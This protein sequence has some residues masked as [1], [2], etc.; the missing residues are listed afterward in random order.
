LAELSDEFVIKVPAG[1]EEMSGV[2][3]AI[4]RL[5]A[6]RALCQRMGHLARGYVEQEHDLSLA[7]DELLCFLDRPQDVA[8]RTAASEGARTAVAAR[9]L[10]RAG[11][12][13]FKEELLRL[14]T[15]NQALLESDHVFT[16]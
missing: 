8:R 13:G 12:S 10:R 14:A 9:R 4:A 6:D 5:T 16:G 11:L 3:A 2:S 7:A 1:D 15:L